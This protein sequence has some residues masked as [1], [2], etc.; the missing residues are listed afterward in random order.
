[1]VGDIAIGFGSL[2]F[3]YALSSHRPLLQLMHT[4]EVDRP[5]ERL[6]SFLVLALAWHIWFTAIG[7][8]RS[9]RLSRAS[10]EFGDICK[11]SLSAAVCVLF[12]CRLRPHSAMQPLSWDLAI[13]SIFG[14]LLLAGLTFSRAIGR[15]T[16]HAMRFHGRNLRNILVLG[17]NDR[18]IQFVDNIWQHPEWGYQLA[19]FAD[20]KWFAQEAPE[21]YRRQLLGGIDQVPD[22]LRSLA[23]DEVIVA[24][25]MASYYR[26]MAWIASLCK[27]QGILV[28]VTGSLFDL[29]DA[30]RRSDGMTGSVTLWDEAESPWESSIKR[31]VDLVVAST[32]L[33]G[34]SPLLVLV[35]IAI[36][37]TSPGP[38][39]FVQERVG[40][41]KRPFRM[42]KLRTMVSDAEARLR[43]FEH[44]N[45]TRGPAFKITHDPRVT[46]LG[47]F[48][49][50]TSLDELPQLINVILGDMSLVGPRPLPL[51]DYRGFSQDWHR[52]RFS[53]KPG[54]TCLWQVRGRST[55]TFD[56]WMELDMDYIDRWSIWL[57]MKILFQT[58][59][60]ILR[61][62]GAF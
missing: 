26:Q 3:S 27:Q 19:G 10:Q 9:H 52:R 5:M 13:V 25:P 22:I 23:L 60:A 50:K 15:A 14:L 43:E 17:T 21:S 8:Y 44:L 37:S 47:R 1:M 18:A 20:D 31:V 7:L 59:P 42:L 4:A 32:V 11:A 29:R 41:G 12:W 38:V 33:V 61:G 28:R 48:L 35:A 2:M 46:R 62:S 58:I 49:R 30:S 34:V 54:I 16:T 40:K 45:E 51:R 56:Q 55:I 39:F 53:V 24:L 36:K 6:L 57:D